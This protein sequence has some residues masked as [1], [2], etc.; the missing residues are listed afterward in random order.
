MVQIGDFDDKRIE[1]D[2]NGDGR[3]AM[4]INLYAGSFFYGSMSVRW[5]G[6]EGEDPH[7]CGWKVSGLN[8]VVG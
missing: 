6:R 2:I 7:C 4:G 5:K 1:V 8:D 3:L